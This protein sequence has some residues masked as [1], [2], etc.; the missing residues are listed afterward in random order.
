MTH[1]TKFNILTNMLEMVAVNEHYTLAVLGVNTKLLGA[2]AGN[3][4]CISGCCG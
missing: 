2:K 1:K 4:G 3:S